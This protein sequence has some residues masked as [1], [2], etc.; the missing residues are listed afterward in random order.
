MDLTTTR[1]L[2]PTFRENHGSGFLF[3]HRDRPR[4]RIRH[5]SPSQRCLLLTR[6]LLLL[7]P[8][9]VACKH[10]WKQ[11]C[12]HPLHQRLVRIWV[13]YRSWLARSSEAYLLNGL[14]LSL[15][16]DSLGIVTS[17]SMAAAAFFAFSCV[18]TVV[19]D[20]GSQM[21]LVFPHQVIIKDTAMIFSHLPSNSLRKLKSTEKL[22]FSAGAS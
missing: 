15:L 14:L 19:V 10:S 21:H 7:E 22:R 3:L 12:D 8:W 4:P 1:L 9:P 17:S 16:D 20:L 5:V 2:C 11:T 13:L 6:F 18:P